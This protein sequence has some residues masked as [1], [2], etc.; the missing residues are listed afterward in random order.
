MKHAFE[1]KPQ[2]MCATYAVYFSCELDGI[3]SKHYGLLG[4]YMTASR[5]EQVENLMR[6]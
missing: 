5:M 1:A 4:S 6:R 3:R 2:I